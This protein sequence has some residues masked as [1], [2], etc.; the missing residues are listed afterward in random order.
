ML[1]YLCKLYEF[2]E[3]VFE[4]DITMLGTQLSDRVHKRIFLH[5]CF[6]ICSLFF[7]KK[8]LLTMLGPQLSDKVHK[9]IFLHDCFAICSHFFF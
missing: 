8:T 4:D 6:A 2:Q 7:K 9:R 1:S 3:L 5:D